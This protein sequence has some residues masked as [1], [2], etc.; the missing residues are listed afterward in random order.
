MITQITIEYAQLDACCPNS[1][2]EYSVTLL[3]CMFGVM[4]FP[5]RLQAISALCRLQTSG[6][7]GLYGTWHHADSAVICEGFGQYLGLIPLDQSILPQSVLA[8]WQDP[9]MIEEEMTAADYENITVT[10]YEKLFFVDNS[11]EILRT[12]RHTSTP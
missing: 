12:W 2:P 9:A 7:L 10:Q 5:E 8:I 6:G 11:K 1:I 4:F 3:G